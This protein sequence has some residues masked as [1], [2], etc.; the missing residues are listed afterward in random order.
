MRFGSVIMFGAAILFAAV[1]TVLVRAAVVGGSSGMT[2][3]AVVVAARDLK[4]GEKL[5]PD[6]VHEAQFPADLLPKG[7]FP[8]RETLFSSGTER[9]LSAS[10]AQNEPILAQRLIDASGSMVGRMTPGMQG[11]TIR[12]NETSSVGGFV[13]P[14]DHVDVLLTQTEKAEA[15]ASHRPYTKTLLKNARVLATDQQTQRR[16]D[17]Q[18]PKTVTLEVSEDDAKRLTLAGT[19]GQLSLALNRGGSSSDSGRIVDSR[20]L[21]GISDKEAVSEDTQVAI[22]RSV[23]RDEYRV[24]QR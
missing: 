14:E 1:A 15:N 23:K 16:Q 10:V 13:Q 5:T 17:S 19:I 7:A 21:L 11:I 4:A 6:A 8:S 24:P 2:K 22:F 20:D 12:V 3:T 18:P 9:I